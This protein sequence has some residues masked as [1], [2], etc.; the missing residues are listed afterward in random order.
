[1]GQK[2]CTEKGAQKLGLLPKKSPVPA[3]SSPMT[4]HRPPADRQD[5]EGERYLVD[6]KSTHGT[7]LE[8]K[9]LKPHEPVKW[10]EGSTVRVVCL[11][12]NGIF[13]WGKM[14]VVLSTG[15]KI[16]WEL[17]FFGDQRKLATEN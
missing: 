13:F 14:G 16:K 15:R 6:L 3:T 17:V 10:P 7:F 1:M 4:S 8:S 12:P 5:V 11:S 2:T 9:R